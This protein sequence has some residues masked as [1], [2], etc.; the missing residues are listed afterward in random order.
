MNIY[1]I[2]SESY[3]Y[4][5][6][7]IQKLIDNHE[8]VIK[9]DL[10]NT[11]LEDILFDACS[12]SLFDNM[13]EIVID[14]SD[15]IFSKS[16]INEELTKYLENP[17]QLS[18]IIFVCKKVDKNNNYY[19][20][21]FK[22]YTVL[23]NTEKKYV[24]K[25]LDV[26]NYVKSKNSHISDNALEY[27]KDATLNNYDLM[28]A[29]VNKLLILGKNNISDELV[30]SLVAPTPDG[31]T[32]RFIDA[33]LLMDDKEALKCIKNMEVLNVDLTKMIALL[34]W[35]VRVTYLIK[36][37]RKDKIILNEVLQT[38]KIPDFKYNKYVKMGNIRSETDFEDIIIE[39]SNLD[40]KIKKYIITKETIGY[41]LLNMFCI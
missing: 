13:K 3:V 24:N 27:I 21:I 6:N 2:I 32:N 22:D 9:Y 1:L 19:K 33:L 35:N 29:E 34:A 31:N 10:A 15:E 17:S 20:K 41:Y 16:Y 38:Y 28:I 5:K 12:V 26:K 36:T 8:N 40:E 18:K 39:L 25:V 23:D 30:Y 11:P 14:N 4:I 37:C 7:N